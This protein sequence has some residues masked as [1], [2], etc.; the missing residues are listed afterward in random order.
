MG[1]KKQKP[2]TER[3]ALSKLNIRIGKRIKELRKEKGLKQE[4]FGRLFN[5]SQNDIT[6]IENGYKNISYSALVDIANKYGLS[7]DYFLKENPVKG[8][9]PELQYLCDYIGLSINTINNL[10]ELKSNNQY[11][12]G[13]NVPIDIIQAITNQLKINQEICRDI[14][15]EIRL[16]HLFLDKAKNDINKDISDRKDLVK[17]ASDIYNSVMGEIYI[18]QNSVSKAIN[19]YLNIEDVQMQYNSFLEQK[20]VIIEKI[21]GEENEEK[22]S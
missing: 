15:A 21:E 8:N 12:N 10:R 3:K 16:A 11:A 19:N 5:L 22:K 6:N 17:D 14:K 9:N 2:K 4:E 18:I 13:D 1:N 7:T 20:R